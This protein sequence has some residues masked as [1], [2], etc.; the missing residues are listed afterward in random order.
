[1]KKSSLIILVGVLFVLTGLAAALIGIFLEKIII[2]FT[3]APFLFLGIFV[4]YSGISELKIKNRELARIEKEFGKID[5]TAQLG[6]KFAPAFFLILFG[7]AVLT[8]FSVVLFFIKPATAYILFGI[9][10]VY[11]IFLN[12]YFINKPERKKSEKQMEKESAGLGF[13]IAF[14][15]ASLATGGLFALGY[16]AYKIVK[17]KKI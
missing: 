12:I 15:F 3:A 4:L 11:G 13:Y 9:N 2:I 7:T 1:M 16:L 10:I 6:R 5:Y 8:G 14:L 17:G